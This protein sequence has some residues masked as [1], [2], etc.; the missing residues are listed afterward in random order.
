MSKYHLIRSFKRAFGV[1]P[2]SYRIQARVEFAKELI[3]RGLP[4]AGWPTRPAS[5][6]MSHFQRSF[7]TFVGLTPGRF[8]EERQSRSIPNAA[9]GIR[10]AHGR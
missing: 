1:P 2:T 9:R 10:C 6:T 8:R 5:A 7:K 4:L 3:A